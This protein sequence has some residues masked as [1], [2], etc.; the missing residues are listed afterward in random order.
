MNEFIYFFGYESPNDKRVNDYWNSDHESS[1]VIR[2]SAENEIRAIEWGDEIAEKFIK[3]LYQDESVSWKSD[4]FAS[5]ILSELEDYLKENWNKIPQV[6][7]GEYP[8][9][10]TFGKHYV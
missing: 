9:L 6:K 7:Y 5:G 1:I 10:E 3:F 4:E 2:I 8:N